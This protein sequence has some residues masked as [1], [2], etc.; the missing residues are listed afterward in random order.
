M[1]FLGI[2]VMALI[3][4]VNTATERRRSRGSGQKMSTG[5]KAGLALAIV[6]SA[7]GLFV[8]GMGIFFV[9]AMSSY[10]SNK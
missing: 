3:Y 9:F 7:L 8:V 6:V 2:F 1:I 4:I 10:G 5:Q